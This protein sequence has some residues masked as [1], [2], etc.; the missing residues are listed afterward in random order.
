MNLLQKMLVSIDQH[1]QAKPELRLR[2][3]NLTRQTELA[4]CVDVANYSASRR[5]GLLGRGMLAAGEGLWIIPCEAVH[6]FGMQF[7]IDLVYLDRDK[8]VKKVRYEVPPR[9]LSACFSAHSVL[10]LPSGSVRRTQT[11]PGDR[12]EF[13]GAPL[14]NEPRCSS[15]VGK[16]RRIF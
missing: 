10:E 13:S 12:L 5:K 11:K 6:T 7:P 16:Q 9:R 4:H 8:R 1:C 3:A 2:I 15:A 14:P